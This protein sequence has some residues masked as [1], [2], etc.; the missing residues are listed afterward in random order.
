MCTLEKV[1][2]YTKKKYVRAAR[3][4]H[5][6][7]SSDECTNINKDCISWRSY[8]A[9]VRSFIP[10]GHNMSTGAPINGPCFRF[11]HFSSF[12]FVYQNTTWFVCPN[13]YLCVWIVP[14]S[15]LIFLYHV[16]D[17]F[18]SYYISIIPFFPSVIS[19]FLQKLI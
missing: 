6:L 11:H 18:I 7:S 17:R 8:L 4:I 19:E 9:E 13:F 12:L 10:L 16:I 14:P 5:Y 3:W 15:S 1:L 2:L